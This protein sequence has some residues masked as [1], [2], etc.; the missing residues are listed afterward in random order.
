MAYQ[1]YAHAQ[2]FKRANRALRSLRTYLGRVFRDIELKTSDEANLPDLRRAPGPRAP[3]APEP[4]RAQSLFA[5][6]ARSRMHRQRQG[7]SALRVRRQG[8]S[9]DHAQPLERGQFIAHVKTLSGNSY[10]GHTLKTV[11]PEIETQ[12]G[13][14]SPTSSPTAAAAATTPRLTTR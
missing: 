2:Q 11:I 1:R 12:I 8:V 4:T 6:R 10:D 5:P 14:A 7:A 9:G 3:L 13:R